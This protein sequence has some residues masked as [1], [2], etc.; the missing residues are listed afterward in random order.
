VTVVSPILIST[1]QPV[2]LATYAARIMSGFLIRAGD[3]ISYAHSP[4]RELGAEVWDRKGV[5]AG[6]KVN[7]AIQVALS[8]IVINAEFAAYAVIK[9]AP[10]VD[11][12]LDRNGNGSVKA[13]IFFRRHPLPLASC[14]STI[15][16]RSVMRVRR[17]SG[18]SSLKHY[19][20][21]AGGAV[22]DG[23]KPSDPFNKNSPLNKDEY[24]NLKAQAWAN[25]ARRAMLTSTR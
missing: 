19:A 24:L 23:D 1:R 20:F 17:R 16:C 4:E 12:E 7:H 10:D 6:E 15:F 5:D 13:S 8:D 9:L 11:Q 22:M 2:C 18:A 3:V 25:T 14:G 21:H